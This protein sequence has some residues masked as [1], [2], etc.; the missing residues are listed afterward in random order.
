MHAYIIELQEINHGNKKNVGGGVYTL[1]LR[2]KIKNKC[3][4]EWCIIEQRPYVYER[5]MLMMLL[6]YV[7]V[8]V[9][10]WVCT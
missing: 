5:W 8:R 6:V 7:C 4:N 9:G 3:W 1:A 2:D 10:V